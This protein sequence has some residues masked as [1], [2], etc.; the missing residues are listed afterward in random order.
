MPIKPL[1]KKPIAER[2]NSF[3]YNYLNIKPSA[4][5]KMLG[6]SPQ[7]LQ[8]GY[9]SGRSL[10]GAPLLVRLSELGCDIVWLLTGKLDHWKYRTVGYEIRIGSLIEKL[11]EKYSLPDDFKPILDMTVPHD[12]YIEYNAGVI[13]WHWKNDHSISQIDLVNLATVLNVSL[14][15]ILTGYEQSEI[16]IN[17]NIID[18]EHSSSILSEE[19]SIVVTKMRLIPEYKESILKL[20][21]STV[22]EKEVLKELK[23]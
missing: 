11:K 13:Y 15:W 14:Y 3:V 20:I 23:K 4:V 17:K 21:D 6:I 16:K 12:N 10:P 19:E 9:L 8:S 22:S 1:D 5:A 18:S 7:A 2:L